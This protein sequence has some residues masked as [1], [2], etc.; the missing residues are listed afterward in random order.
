MN[1]FL[2]HAH[3][4]TLLLLDE[5]G[6]GT[7]PE[8]GG[9]LAAVFYEELYQKGVYAVITTH[10]TNIK[11]LTSSMPQAIN[12]CMLFD[13]KSL[14][15][16]YQLSTG[17]PGSS[18]TFEVAKYNGIPDELLE[19]AK[20]N[21]SEYKISLEYFT[22]KINNMICSKE[23]N[24]DAYAY[25]VMD[26]PFIQDDVKDEIYNYINKKYNNIYTEQLIKK[27]LL[28]YDNPSF[29]KNNSLFK[30]WFLRNSV[31]EKIIKKIYNNMACDDYDI[32]ESFKRDNKLH[33][34]LFL[35][36]C[37]ILPS[38]NVK[39]LLSR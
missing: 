15:P 24:I 9:A 23:H 26:A 17:Q 5:F 32:N 19:K 12:A 33:L 37:S 18:F 31:C 25:N 4:E 2:Q 14:E 8:L 30:I 34:K 6:S 36:G 22:F 28:F 39:K 11:I 16:L 21:V 38:F 35:L 1:F 3:Q 29:D 27:L 10:Y 20:L 7:D 13:T